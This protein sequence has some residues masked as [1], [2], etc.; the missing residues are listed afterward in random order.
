MTRLKT[1]KVRNEF[2]AVLKRV[3]S[4]GERIVLQRRGQDVAALVPL[5]DYT[6]LQDIEDRIDLADARAALAEAEE[7][8]T[9]PL[10]K[11]LAE[12]GI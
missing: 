6:L 12:L 11:L 7:K 4:R 1:T 2:G 9:I 10:E 8:G 5:E 3:S